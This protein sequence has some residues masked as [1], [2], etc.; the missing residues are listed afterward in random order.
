MGFHI[1]YVLVFNKGVLG[2]FYGSL[3]AGVLNL[4]ILAFLMISLTTIKLRRT[5]LSEPLSYSIPI[6]PST[7]VGNITV[8]ADRFLLQQYID[9]N[10]LGLYSVSLK[11]ASL[12]SQLH[13]AL[14]LSFV[15]FMFKTV[16]ET[17]ESWKT[18]LAKMNN[19]YVFPLLL[20]VFSVSIFIDDYVIF[21]GQETYFEIVNIVPFLSFVAL[22]PCLYLYMS[23]GIVLSKKT[24]LLTIPVS[25]Q[26]LV[27]IGLGIVLLPKFQVTGIIITNAAAG[28]IFLMVSIIISNK[29]SEW[30]GHLNTILIYI[31]LSIAL[32]LIRRVIDADSFILNI[33]VDLLFVAIFTIF[34]VKMLQRS[35]R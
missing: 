7:L 18:I 17:K 33:I 13:N 23:P 11:F 16:S 24:K 1:L 31:L 29:V 6:I 26:L 34:G 22:L 4:I 8:Q 27:M 3:V 2:Y 5:H 9:L 25:I 10:S 28:T 14:K 21:T 20:M 15:P 12:V 19:F 35:I 32:L 30:R